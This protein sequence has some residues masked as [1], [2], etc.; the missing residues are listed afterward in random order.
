[1]LRCPGVRVLSVVFVGTSFTG[2]ALPWGQITLLVSNV[3]TGVV[4]V[5]SDH[6]A[7][8]E[9]VWGGLNSSDPAGSTDLDPFLLLSVWRRISDSIKYWFLGNVIIPPLKGLDRARLRLLNWYINGFPRVIRPTVFLFWAHILIVF[10]HEW[11]YPYLAASFLVGTLRRLREASESESPFLRVWVDTFINCTFYIGVFS[12]CVF[13]ILRWELYWIA[14]MEEYV[15]AGR[16][17]LNLSNPYVVD[18]L[19]RCDELMGSC[20][21]ATFCHVVGVLCRV[22]EVTGYPIILNF[23]IPGL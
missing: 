6:P 2:Y 5:F 10:K 20:F 23:I 3:F 8:A 16:P 14:H 21:S 17:E 13:W 15:S 12:N 9:L 7:G 19:Y 11:F 1:M 22:S 18:L 4:Q